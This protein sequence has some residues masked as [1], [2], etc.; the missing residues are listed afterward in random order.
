MA[1]YRDTALG[2]HDA[3][4][5]VN[6]S[7]A[8]PL[9]FI[10]RGW[11][12]M[13]WTWR[14]CILQYV[15]NR[16]G[17][18]LT[19][20]MGTALHYAAAGRIGNLTGASTKAKLVTDDTF[21]AAGALVGSNEWPSYVFSTVGTTIGERRQIFGNSAA[22]GASTIDVVPDPRLNRDLG[23]VGGLPTRDVNAYAT[24]PDATTDYSVFCPWE[25]VATD[26]DALVT[27]RLQGVVLSTSITDGN[28]GVIQ[29]TGP[30]IA[31][32]DGT[33][34]LVAGDSLI[35]DAVAG[36][37]SK[38]VVTDGNAVTIAAEITRAR[39]ASAW[40]LDAYTTNSADR[41]HVMLTGSTANYPYPITIS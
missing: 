41:R 19:E 9:P 30:A 36:V 5:N 1:I 17:G 29:I 26:I 14:G 34:D 2:L 20:G 37:L 38:W 24:L 18:A 31:L 12:G 8:S 15:Q 13:A 28:F 21:S 3:Y 27:S 35:P 25:V 6:D 32:V 40:I 33:T 22:A 39:L 11:P 23:P 4:R 10:G 7:A 16:S